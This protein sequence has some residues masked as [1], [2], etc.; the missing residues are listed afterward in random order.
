MFPKG[1]DHQ[2]Q[3]WL[4]ANHAVFDADVRAI[5]VVCKSKTCC[6]A[7]RSVKDELPFPALFDQDVNSGLSN[8]LSS[9]FGLLC[10]AR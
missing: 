10:V 2:L 7:F 6:L 8:K 1:K 3:V 4:V 5:I 9:C